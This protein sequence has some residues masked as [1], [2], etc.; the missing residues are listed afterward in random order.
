M[1]GKDIYLCLTWR[2]DKKVSELASVSVF[3]LFKA[4]L[5]TVSDEQASKLK[6]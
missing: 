4:G 2:T 6:R 3:T 1:S 5:D